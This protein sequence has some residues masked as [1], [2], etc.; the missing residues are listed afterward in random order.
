MTAFLVLFT[1]CAGLALS[2]GALRLGRWASRKGIVCRL[3]GHRWETRER[4][5]YFPSEAALMRGELR[6]CRRCRGAHS[7]GVKIVGSW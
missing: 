5:V 3:L 4:T 1:L 2:L 6:W 7:E